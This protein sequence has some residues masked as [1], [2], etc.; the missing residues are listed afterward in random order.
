MIKIAKLYKEI[1]LQIIDMLNKDET[2]KIEELLNKRQEILEI[3][4]NPKELKK[5]LINDG[6]LDIDKDIH[7]L[8][9]DNISKIKNEIKEYKVTQR[10]NNYY[11]H[12]SKEKLNIFNKKV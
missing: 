2:E 3:G 4:E 5:L 6:I 1:S 11:S 8:L 7:K 9:S 12:F 10:A